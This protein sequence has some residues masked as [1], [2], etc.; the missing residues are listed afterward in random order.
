M[1]KGTI[2]VRLKLAVDAVVLFYLLCFILFLYFA[3]CFVFHVVVVWLSLL[4]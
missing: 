2:G 3:R 4:P 1:C